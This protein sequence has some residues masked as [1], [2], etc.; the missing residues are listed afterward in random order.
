MTEP[1]YITVTHR[2]WFGFLPVY[3]GGVNTGCPMLIPR[4]PLTGWLITVSAFIFNTLPGDGF[5]IRI[6]GKTTRQFR[7]RIP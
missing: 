7:V 6:T 1:L 3:V 5:P 2:G 4:I